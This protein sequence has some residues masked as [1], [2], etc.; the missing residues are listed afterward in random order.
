MP[1]GL[2]N[3][4][5]VCC[6]SGH[7]AAVRAD[8]TVVCWGNN[9][10]GQCNVP[11]VLDSVV[12]LSCGGDHTAAVRADGSVVCWGR[13]EHGQCNVPDG[14]LCLLDGVSEGYVLK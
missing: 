6:G 13:N 4:V 8:G 5:V 3:V 2:S 11:V 14:L 10:Y 12:M 9:D 1:T 7:T